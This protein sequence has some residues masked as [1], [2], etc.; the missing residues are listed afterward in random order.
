[1]VSQDHE[2]DSEFHHYRSHLLLNNRCRVKR[3]CRQGWHDIS[4]RFQVTVAGLQ[5]ALW[6]VVSWKLSLVMSVWED[7]AGFL[8]L[9]L[10]DSTI[11]AELC[12]SST[13]YEYVRD[14]DIIHNTPK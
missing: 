1:M 4:C 9:R 6:E 14:H 8:M 10:I 7:D 2:P 11:D 5:S 12:Y 13:T 3:A